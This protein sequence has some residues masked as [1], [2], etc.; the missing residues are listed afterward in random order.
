VLSLVYVSLVALSPIMR[1]T[2]LDE[3]E[4]ISISRNSQLGITGSLIV[5]PSYFA[6]L[7]E[8]GKSEIDLVMASINRDRRHREIRVLRRSFKRTRL[9]PRW[10]MARFDAKNFGRNSIEKILGEAH[11]EGAEAARR[12]DRLFEAIVVTRTESRA[13]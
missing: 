9:C 4:A 6:Q 5:A 3:I 13:I 8:G 2:A 7:L 11:S 10:H 12:L 1:R